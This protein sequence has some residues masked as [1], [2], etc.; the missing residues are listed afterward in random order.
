MTTPLILL[1]AVLISLYTTYLVNVAAAGLYLSDYD[2]QKFFA[3]L[4]P[5][6]REFV[7]F[8]M[9]NPARMGNTAILVEDICLAANSVILFYLGLRWI[10]LEGFSY[11]AGIVLAFVGAFL[12]VGL[13]ELIAPLV[14]QERA[15]NVFRRR[16]WLLRPI[17]AVTS[18][19]V[20]LMLRHKER[21]S[22]DTEM[23]ERK[24]EIVE[25]AIESLA[26]SAG[27]GEP[28]MEREERRMIEK[29]FDLGE[30]EVREVMVPRIDMNAIE[31][32]TSFAEVQQLAARTG[33]SRFPL[34][35][36]DADNILGIIYLKD[37]FA[38]MPFAEGDFDLEKLARKP[39][40]VPESKMLDKL[41]EEFKLQRNHMA[42]VVDEFGGTAGL[43]TM[44]DLLELI[45]GDIQDEHDTEE[46]EL[47]K[48]SDN[49]YLLS[50]N[51]SMDD[52][53]EQLDLP[54]EE[55][56]F[57]TVGGYIYDLVGSLPNVGDKIETDGLRFVVEKIRG[58][59]IE[60][61][62]LILLPE[63]E[64]QDDD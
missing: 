32:G 54:L 24:E 46:A 45:V 15:L 20:S 21:R 37:L 33:Y 3:S 17:L 39:Y 42:I 50:A 58:Q 51:L 59:R 25:R 5:R 2:E 30:T 8:L 18:P 31:V 56:E 10:P 43:V 60:K 63:Q 14:R 6:T 19:A 38:A 16:T 57:E 36:E 29:I 40:F 28:L 34:Y 61:V 44:E 13:A 4:K 23:D 27:I 47:V 11:L 26:D 7:S 62:K 52:L 49:V 35:R 22:N 41:L 53:A 9:K 55:K 64:L 48:I 12:H 1:L